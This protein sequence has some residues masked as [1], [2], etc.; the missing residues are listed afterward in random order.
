MEMD[1]WVNPPEGR[2]IFMVYF[3][4][5]TT[6]PDWLLLHCIS[7]LQVINVKPVTS[8]YTHHDTFNYTPACSPVL[9]DNTECMHIFV[10]NIMKMHMLWIACVIPFVQTW[11]RAS[12]KFQTFVWI[13]WLLPTIRYNTC[14]IITRCAPAPHTFLLLPLL[15]IT[16]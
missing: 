15:C 16:D 5:Y 1:L 6:D 4:T 14:Q 11:K 8:D 7:S 13:K 2:I 3:V 9:F 12:I 10:C